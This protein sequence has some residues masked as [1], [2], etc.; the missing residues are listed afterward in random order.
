MYTA[1]VS[2][3]KSPPSQSTLKKHA[4]C[5][6]FYLGCGTINP[7]LALIGHKAHFFGSARRNR[8]QIPARMVKRRGGEAAPRA[9]ATYKPARRHLIARA[10]SDERVQQLLSG[11]F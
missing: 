5:F 3:R 6:S 7:N 2:E 1:P 8:T 4:F 9:R 11:A 10:R